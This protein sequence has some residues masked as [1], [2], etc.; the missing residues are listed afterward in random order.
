MGKMSSGFQDVGT[1][2]D[3]LDWVRVASP[4]VMR[5]PMGSSSA[6]HPGSRVMSKVPETEALW[7]LPLQLMV[8]RPWTRV[9]TRNV[10][11]G[12]SGDLGLG[13][14]DQ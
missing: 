7:D 1:W 6:V 8:A 10:S 14:A 5:K 11:G 13:G 9:A 4:A 2:T 12:H 3:R